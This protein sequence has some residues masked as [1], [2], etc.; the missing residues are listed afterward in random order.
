MI[1][2]R[3]E[4]PQK[5]AIESIDLIEPQVFD[6]DNGLKMFL[7]Q[8]EEVDLVKVEFIF[9]N[10]F[11]ALQSP[12]LNP[13]L[14]GMLKEGTLT[15]MSAQIAEEIDFYGA[16]LIPEYGYDQ[17][18]LNLYSL[19]KY[20]PKVL[21][22]VQD[23]LKNA[24]FPEEELE[25]FKRNNKQKL[26]VSLQKNDFVARR[27]FYK[28]LF[29]DEHY[30]GYTPDVESYDSLTRESLLELYKKEIQP[31]NCTLIVSGN[32]SADLI[33]QIEEL[34]VADWR[35]SQLY[36][37]DSLFLLADVEPQNIVEERTDALQ[38]AIRLGM[39]MINRTH[40]D[41]PAVQFVNTLFGGYFGSRLM[42]NI[43]EEKGYTYSIGSAVASLKY[44]GFFTIASEV[45]AESTALTMLEIEKEFDILCSIV[46][47]EAEVELV[48]N[49]ILGSMMGSL[50]SIFSHADKFKAVYFYGM[51]NDYYKQYN[52]VIRSMTA[53]KVLQIAQ[54]Y[55]NFNQLV[56]I[57]VGKMN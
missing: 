13:C 57:V 44:T 43:R 29:G 31:K 49:Y 55:F 45:A 50:E 9:D 48:R 5:H 12:L 46:P 6:Y 10:V 28:S 37:K 56:Q 35:N 32:V 47:D 51:T 11:N 3:V 15:R 20:L 8:T 18:S 19:P 24:I 41:F 2:N 30:Y 42:R 40:D 53:E 17:M 36:S 52:T 54:K 23:I 34:F 25:T 21:H 27:L 39:P 16:Y 4:A 33:T 1:L 26:Q 38:S 14:S 7:F 22:I